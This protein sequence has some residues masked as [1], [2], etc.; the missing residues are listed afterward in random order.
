MIQEEKEEIKQVKMKDIQAKADEKKCPV[1]KS[2]VFVDEFL[3]GPMCGR[4]FPCSFGSYETRIRIKR[5]IDGNATDEDIETI[6]KICSHM[7]V[8]SFCKK[9]KDTAKYILEQTDYKEF[10]GHISGT[11]PSSECVAHIKYVIIPEN[12]TMCGDCLD[13]CKDN[14]II[15]EKKK[16]YL[17]G[18]LTFEIVQKRCTKCGECIKV[19]KYEA[20]KL[21]SAK[22]ITEKKA[23]GAQR[24]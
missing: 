13:A 17:T 4:C 19:C 6:N 7:L 18:Y 14:A 16:P 15:G 10:S 21:V 11:C 8:A 22:E 2:L 24:S 23:V 12:C 20:I 1:Q 5:L 9:G 3:A